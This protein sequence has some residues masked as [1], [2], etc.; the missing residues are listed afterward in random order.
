MPSIVLRFILPHPAGASGDKLKSLSL[1]DCADILPSGAGSTGSDGGT[2]DANG[3]DLVSSFLFK[4]LDESRGPH[5][6]AWGRRPTPKGS[7]DK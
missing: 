4:D 5:G 1:L 3:L 6:Q 2:A 7:I